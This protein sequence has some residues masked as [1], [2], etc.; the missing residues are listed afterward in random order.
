MKNLT[1]V[2]WFIEQI[3]H[4]SIPIYD[5]NV[6]IDI[7]KEIIEQAKQME[8]EQIIDAYRNGFSNGLHLD[9]NGA[10]DYYTETFKK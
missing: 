7:P 3:N 8:R 5:T 1:A 9:S 2:E 6:R 10:I 4:K